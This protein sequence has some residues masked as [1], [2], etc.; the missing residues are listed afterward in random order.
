MTGVPLDGRDP[1][2]PKHGMNQYESII[3]RWWNM[4]KYDEV[5]VWAVHFWD[6]KSHWTR[7]QSQKWC[8]TI[9]KEA[10]AA[11]SQKKSENFSYQEHLSRPILCH[12]CREQNSNDLDSPSTLGTSWATDS[13]YT[14]TGIIKSITTTSTNNTSGVSREPKEPK[15]PKAQ[16]PVL[17]MATFLWGKWWSTN[18]S[19]GTPFS[20]GI[21]D[22]HT[23]IAYNSLWF[24]LKL[25]KCKI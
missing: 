7:K 24:F 2:H 13:T 6:K 21:I 10:E 15:E 3:I 22:G 11:L 25:E 23:L 9:E 16:D 12:F 14:I 18:G 8:K 20:T 4:M 17:Q 19:R 1:C 5:S